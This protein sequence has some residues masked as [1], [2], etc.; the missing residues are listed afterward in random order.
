MN[1][2]SDSPHELDQYYDM[3]HRIEQLEEALIT[4]ELCFK[5]QIEIN[6]KIVSTLKL[7]LADLTVKPQ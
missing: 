1:N 2:H 3:N 7:L 4:L 6:Y 5:E